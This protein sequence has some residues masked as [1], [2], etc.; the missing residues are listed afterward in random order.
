VPNEIGTEAYILIKGSKRTGV[1]PGLAETLAAV[2][3]LGDGLVRTST[4]DTRV[5]NVVNSAAE[6]VSTL[7]TGS[8]SAVLDESGSRA[9]RGEHCH[10]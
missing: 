8:A 6:P 2:G 1:G 4:L 7:V 9:R 10:S 5:Q 3:H